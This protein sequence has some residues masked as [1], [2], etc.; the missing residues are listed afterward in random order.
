MSIKQLAVKIPLLAN[1][2]ATVQQNLTHE[3]LVNFSECS[4]EL[5]VNE[6]PSFI[7]LYM[8]NAFERVTN[9]IKF[10]FTKQQIAKIINNSE[11][12]AIEW[13]EAASKNIPLHELLVLEWLMFTLIEGATC[14]KPLNASEVCYFIASHWSNLLN[15]KEYNLLTN[16]SNIKGN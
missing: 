8:P 7:N 9:V 2:L 12:Y 16:I 4:E 6:L 14:S 5:A 1:E 10:L 3:Q 15:P 13:Q 11:F